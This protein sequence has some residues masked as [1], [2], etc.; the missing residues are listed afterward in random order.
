MKFHLRLRQQAIDGRQKQCAM[1]TTS[2]LPMLGKNA[3]F[4]ENRHTLPRGGRFNCENLHR[5][6][7]ACPKSSAV[8]V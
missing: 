6:Y 3:G 5:G 7:K 1:G 8:I 4:I 2:L